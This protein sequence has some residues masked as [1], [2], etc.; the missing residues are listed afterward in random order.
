MALE[1]R[2]PFWSESLEVLRSPSE[3]ESSQKQLKCEP[4]ISAFEFA[5]GLIARRIVNIGSV[6][7]VSLPIYRQRSRRP[8]PFR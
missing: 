8:F 3:T 5:A 1:P 2:I 6:R 7:R 4:L